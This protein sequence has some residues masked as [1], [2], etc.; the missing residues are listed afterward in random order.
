MGDKASIASERAPTEAAHWTETAMRLG[1]ALLFLYLFL[2]GVK[3]LETGISSF[4]SDFVDSVFASVA[5]PMAGLA[6]GILATVLVQSSSVTTATIVGLVGSGVLPVETAVPMVMGA[7]I[8]T[9]VTNTL[10]SLGHVRQ[11]AY[12]ERAFAAA[13]I[14]DYFNI[15]AV[16]ILLPLEIWFGLV[17]RIAAWAAEIVGE[18]LPRGGTGSSPVKS[19]IAAPVEWIEE[20]ID[21]LGWGSA[22]AA[23]LLVLGLVLIFAALWMITR[24]MKQVMSGRIENAINGILGRGAG[25]GALIVGLVMTIAVQS[26]SITT[27][28]LVPL[29]A[30]GV[31]SL[32]N[33]FP[34]TLGAN[35]GTTITA[36]L[37]SLAADSPDAL[38][39]ALAH[40]TFNVLGILIIYPVPRIRAIPLRMA[41][42]T[43]VVAT[44]RKSLVAAYVIGLFVVFPLAIL[45]IA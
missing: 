39:I 35:I 21:S 2:V 16:A 4:G 14:H 15:I 17:S 32:Q 44:R 10:A 38:V 28:I 22:E 7:N 5:N 9:T 23:I 26:S 42:W 3:A 8:G 18:I 19:A 36:L 27:S 20:T 24:Q 37:A 41:E 1:L 31:L 25:A 40:V 45:L 33:A 13:T 12:F 29:V 34:V 6:A 43:G 11:G 30:A